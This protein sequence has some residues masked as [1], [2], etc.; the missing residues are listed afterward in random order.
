MKLGSCLQAYRFNS[1]GSHLS[2]PRSLS[3]ADGVEVVRIQEPCPHICCSSLGRPGIRCRQACCEEA[4]G[5]NLAQAK[6]LKSCKKG[7][8]ISRST[9]QSNIMHTENHTVSFWGTNSGCWALGFEGLGF[10]F[11]SSPWLFVRLDIF[12]LQ[13]LHAQIYWCTV[14]LLSD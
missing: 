3:R 2:C 1:L 9:S 6:T 5:S 4:D 12:G 14:L 8:G 13:D 11:F 10:G 7:T